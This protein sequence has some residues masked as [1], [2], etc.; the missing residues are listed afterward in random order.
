MRR[1]FIL[2]LHIS[3]DSSIPV[4]DGVRKDHKTVAPG[5]ETAGPPVRP[6]CYANEAPN[7]R[8]SNFLSKIINDYT[9]AVDDHHEVRSSEE[10]S[11]LFD[12]YN[13]DTDPE[14]KKRS[15]C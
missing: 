8:I 7:F 9:D 6:I 14:V 15:L 5:Q 4:M 3:S 1:E 12:S 10:I 11:S 2:P 13:S